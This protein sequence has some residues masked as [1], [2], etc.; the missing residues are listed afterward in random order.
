MTCLYES[1]YDNFIRAF[2]QIANY[3]Y[4][5]KGGSTFKGPNQVSLKQKVI[6]KCGDPK[7]LA[8]AEDLTTRY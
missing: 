8:E 5:L 3:R 4:R 2:M 6:A 1:T 7:L